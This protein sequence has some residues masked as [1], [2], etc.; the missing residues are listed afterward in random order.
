MK[1][2]VWKII[3]FIIITSLEFSIAQPGE[4]LLI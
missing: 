4:Y 3:C 2:Y 1:I